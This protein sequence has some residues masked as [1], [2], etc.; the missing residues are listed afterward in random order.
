[1][2]T[3]LQTFGFKVFAAREGVSLIASFALSELFY[4]FH[5]FTL[6]AGAMLGTWYL[7]S[8]AGSKLVKNG[9]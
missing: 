3:M 2:H 6:E 1:M 4:K 9:S 7:L 5:S 8:W